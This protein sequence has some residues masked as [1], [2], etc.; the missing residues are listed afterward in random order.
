MHSLMNWCVCIYM[1][2]RKG[3][4]IKD[5]IWFVMLSS[6]QVTGDRQVKP[7]SVLGPM[8]NP[9]GSLNDVLHRIFPYSAEITTKQILLF[10]SGACPARCRRRR[11]PHPTTRCILLRRTVLAPLHSTAGVLHYSVLPVF[12]YCL[13]NLECV[14]NLPAY[15]V[16]SST[17]L[18]NVTA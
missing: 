5:I 13:G 14:V 17:Q 9:V 2:S 10:T 12:N 3:W 11:T 15:P 6:L 8:L 18:Q 4:V 7:A 1:A 16:M